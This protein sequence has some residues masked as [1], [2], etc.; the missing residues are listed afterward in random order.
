MLKEGD[1]DVLIIDEERINNPNLEVL[2]I[3]RVPYVL[4]SKKSI[5]IFK[6]LQ[7]IL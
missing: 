4:V 6:K 7:K 3:E 1:L 5:Q 2:T